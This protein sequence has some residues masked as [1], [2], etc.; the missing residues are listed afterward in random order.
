MNLWSNPRSDRTLAGAVS[1]SG[2]FRR[3]GNG[4]R[5]LFQRFSSNST[6]PGVENQEP[7][8]QVAL[9]LRRLCAVAWPR[10]L[11]VHRWRLCDHYRQVYIPLSLAKLRG[12]LLNSG[13][14]API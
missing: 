14:P 11:C 8:S 6:L 9:V 1:I 3:D 2:L 10:S 5:L 7:V 13:V 12:G 4:N